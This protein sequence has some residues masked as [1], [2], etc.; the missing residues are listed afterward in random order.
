MKDISSVSWLE[1]STTLSMIRRTV[2]IE[3]Q[4]VPEEE[5]WDT[6]DEESSTIHLLAMDSDTPIGTLRIVKEPNFK[7]KI[8]RLAVL[9]QYRRQ[10]WA[11][12]LLRK[13]LELI[14]SQEFS[15]VYLH[16]QLEAQ[17]LYK[18]LGFIEEG[19]IFLDAG[20]QHQA[21]Y[22]DL[23]NTQLLPSVFQSQVL[24]V[25]SP[26]G[27]RHHIQS[28]VRFARRQVFISS[29]KLRDDIFSNDVLIDALSLFT[30]S[31]RHAEIKILI[32]DKSSLKHRRLPII[33][34]AQRLSSKIQVKVL[35]ND[36][37]D[38][39]S[40]VCCD[41]NTLVFFNNEDNPLSG[42]AC[43]EAKQEALQRIEAFEHNWNHCAE[44]DPEL[45]Q[46]I[47]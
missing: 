44:H 6:S 30:R 4:A 12:S 39:E 24:R 1:H 3:E 29:K 10:G 47:I 2:F 27:F 31:D 28:Q 23:N 13:A 20:I 14:C 37:G 8:T 17:A 18:K 46:F 45:S 25:D 33:K 11:I 9:K 16:A 15:G 42:F 7:F 36:N 22:L 35:L 21:M 26:A 43:Y 38:S 34:L 19:D 40:F 5:E 32:H 41:K